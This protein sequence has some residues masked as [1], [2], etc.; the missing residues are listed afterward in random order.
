L[1]ETSSEQAAEFLRLLLPLMSRHHVPATPPNYA[2]WFAYVS[3][4]NPALREE[5]DRLVAA[6]EAFTPAVNTLLHRRYV[7][8]QDVGEIEQVRNDLHLLIQEVSGTLRTA[9]NEARTFGNTLEGFA[10]EVGRSDDLHTLGRLL[11][12]LIR[13]TRDMRRHTGE[14]EIQFAS[15][16]REIEHLQSQLE[17]ER[18]RAMSDP[19]TG[20]FNRTALFSQLDSTIAE[21]KAGKPLSVIMFDIDHFKKINDNH[22]H[23]IGDRVIRFVGQTLKRSIKGKDIAARFGGEEF[24][25]ILPNTGLAGAMA[26]AQ[27]VRRLIEDAQLVRAD[28]KQPLSDITISAGIATYRGGENAMAFIDRADKALYRAKREGRNRVCEAT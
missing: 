10:D 11:G 14:V 24:T 9:G 8:E 18:R 25:V 22:G 20:L 28:N 19:L 4:E 12:N 3:G 21:A 7:V 15:K 13:E 23:L 2:V 26:V 5:I 1:D 16:S 27:S 17:A 6:G